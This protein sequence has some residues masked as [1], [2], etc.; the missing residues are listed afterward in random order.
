MRENSERRS[1]EIREFLVMIL[2]G[3]FGYSPMIQESIPMQG[4]RFMLG[5]PYKIYRQVIREHKKSVEK[6]LAEL[7]VTQTAGFTDVLVQHI[8]EDEEDMIVTKL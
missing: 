3:F 6:T 8:P 4:Y 7:E 2:L 1:Q 5:T